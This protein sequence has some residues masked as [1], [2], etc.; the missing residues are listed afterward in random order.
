LQYWV[1]EEIEVAALIIRRSM[2]PGIRQITYLAQLN[3]FSAHF[4]C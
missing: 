3:I 2:H 1:P 4:P